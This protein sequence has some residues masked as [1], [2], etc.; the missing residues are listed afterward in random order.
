MFSTNFKPGTL[1][2]YLRVPGIVKDVEKLNRLYRLFSEVLDRLEE[3]GGRT[4][5][6]EKYNDNRQVH[7]DAP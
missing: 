2:L 5:A 7:S 1:E 3:I 4:V 6:R